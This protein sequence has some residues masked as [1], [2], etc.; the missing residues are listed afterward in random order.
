MTEE[1]RAA[2]N[3]RFAA[4]HEL[5][6]LFREQLEAGRKVR[7][8]PQGVS[9]M[10]MLRPG[11]DAVVLSAVTGRLQKYDLPLYQRENGAYILHRIVEA[12]DTYTCIGDNQFVPERG[13]EHGQ[14]I[15]V[16][17]AFYRGGREISVRN[18]GYRIYCRL[19][20]KTR[21]FRKFLYR[22]VNFLRRKLR[23]WPQNDDS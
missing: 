5:M 13:V 1:N 22:C 21:R 8:S 6:P 19:W 15:A 9:M 12:G 11:I 14:M 3:S 2:V 10:P 7:F 20:H 16:V 17:T 18:P 4:M 23:C